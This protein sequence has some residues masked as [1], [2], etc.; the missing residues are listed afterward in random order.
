MEKKKMADWLDGKNNNNS[1]N[2]NWKSINKSLG[3]LIVAFS[4]RIFPFVKY[5][6]TY[7]LFDDDDAAAIDDGVSLL[8]GNPFKSEI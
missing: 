1:N 6:V 7:L 5:R 3:R 2:G 4:K 8:A